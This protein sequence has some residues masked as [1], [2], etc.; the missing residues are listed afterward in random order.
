MSIYRGPKLWQNLQVP[1][2]VTGT[3]ENQITKLN[4]E[5]AGEYLGLKCEGNR[6]IQ[7]SRGVQH[8]RY[9]RENDK[10]GRSCGGKIA[11]L[12]KQKSS[13]SLEITSS[14]SI[15]QAPTFLF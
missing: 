1:A 9:W 3:L 15:V 12:R 5:R 11:M 13:S 6:V 4:Q 14:A 2:N 8:D 7:Q 10:E